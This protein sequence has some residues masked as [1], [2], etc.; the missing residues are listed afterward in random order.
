MGQPSAPR[1]WQMHVTGDGDQ[2][3]AYYVNPQ[4]G[5]T[6]W[7]P[8]CIGEGFALVPLRPA[9]HTATTG[10]RAEVDGKE[11]AGD[12]D[13]TRQRD[14]GK[15]RREPDVASHTAADKHARAEQLL[16]EI[17]ARTEAVCHMSPAQQAME[18][19][20][21]AVLSTQLDSMTAQLDSQEADWTLHWDAQWGS[22]YYESV[23]TGPQW[24]PPIVQGGFT[25]MP[26]PQAQGAEAR[27]GPGAM[28]EGRAGGSSVA[29][30]YDSD[31]KYKAAAPTASGLTAQAAKLH[32]QIRNRAKAASDMDT[33]M[34]PAEMQAI[35]ELCQEFDAIA[36]QFDA[37]VGQ[38]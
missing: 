21:L 22:I 13:T 4:T 14:S 10:S 8:P 35:Q 11:N 32:T 2:A 18:L 23:H 26:L 9:V 36:A 33:T 6:Q 30:T 12:N 19:H 38:P 3:Q 1:Y 29:G 31:K 16:A 24:L 15:K 5:G 17:C 25:M 7:L 20:E 28:N 34:R 37:I 27:Y